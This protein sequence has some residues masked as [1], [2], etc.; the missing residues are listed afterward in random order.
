MIPQLTTLIITLVIMSCPGL[1]RAR[2]VKKTL[3]AESVTASDLPVV[4]LP[5]ASS[6]DGRALMGNQKR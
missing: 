6:G 2:F 3:E 4:I 1:Q 5:P